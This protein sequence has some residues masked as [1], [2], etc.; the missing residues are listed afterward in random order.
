MAGLER[1]RLV[2]ETRCATHLDCQ[3]VWETSRVGVGGVSAESPVAQEGWA[4]SNPRLRGPDWWWGKAGGSYGES[5]Q[6]LAG[7]SQEPGGT[8]ARS[9][10]RCSGGV[11]KRI[12]IQSQTRWETHQHG[13]LHLWSVNYIS[14]RFYLEVWVC[15]WLWKVKIIRAGRFVGSRMIKEVNKGKKDGRKERMRNF[16]TS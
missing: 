11:R 6:D 3:G 5:T 4:R 12:Q 9:W 8:W 1:A 7:K 13:E 15:R 16:Y 14:A 2:A 10:E